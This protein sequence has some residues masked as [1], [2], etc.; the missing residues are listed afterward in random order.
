MYKHAYFVQIMDILFP[1]FYQQSTFMHVIKVLVY[2]TYT[3]FF[4]IF[5]STNYIFVWYIGHGR[6]NTW[7]STKR[8]LWSTINWIQKVANID[9]FSFLAHFFLHVL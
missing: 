3:E 5:F 2:H 9:L 4:V 1:N 8:I 7:R 6:D